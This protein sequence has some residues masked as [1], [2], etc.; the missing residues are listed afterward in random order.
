MLHWSFVKGDKFKEGLDFMKRKFLVCDCS[1]SQK[2][3]IIV[4]SMYWKTSFNDWNHLFRF[5]DF[6]DGKYLK[7]LMD[8][9]LQLLQCALNCKILI[10]KEL[11][12]PL[13][14]RLH[15]IGDLEQLLN[16]AY[17][18]WSDYIVFCSIFFQDSQF[19]W[20]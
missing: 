3:Y 10:L 8:D 11:T 7:Y 15:S 5:K 13:C 12:K 2:I 4:T 1:T 17:T 18:E 19:Q 20:R 9:K 14:H 6:M 16:I